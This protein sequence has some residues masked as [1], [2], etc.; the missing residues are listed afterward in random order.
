MRRP[1]GSKP[2]LWEFTALAFPFTRLGFC[3]REAH[4]YKSI[5]L[6]GGI[7]YMQSQESEKRKSLSLVSV[8]KRVCRIARI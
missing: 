2:N 4:D 7:Y 3:R 1:L 8:P 6:F 5:A